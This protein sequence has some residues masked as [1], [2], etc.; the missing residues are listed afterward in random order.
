MSIIVVPLIAPCA[1]SAS[2]SILQ[3]IAVKLS[4]EMTFFRLHR[5]VMMAITSMEMAVALNVS[6]KP[7]IFAME[8][9]ETLA[10]AVNVKII[11]SIAPL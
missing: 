7:L 8:L 6:S 11:V 3:T 4:V 9:S 2:F 10:I 1:S 5:S